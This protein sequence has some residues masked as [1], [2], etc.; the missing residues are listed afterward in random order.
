MGLFFKFGQAVHEIFEFLYLENN[1]FL[2]W[3]V[4]ICK[5]ILKIGMAP[6]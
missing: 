6:E 4:G 2:D 5:W 3:I 1:G